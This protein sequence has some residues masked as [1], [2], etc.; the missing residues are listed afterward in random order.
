MRSCRPEPC[1]P[2]RGPSPWSSPSRGRGPPSSCPEP[3]CSCSAAVE[4]PERG[5]RRRP[6]RGRWCSPIGR[7]GAVLGAAAVDRSSPIGCCH[8]ARRPLCT[9][10]RLFPLDSYRG[11]V[12]DTRSASRWI[13]DNAAQCVDCSALTGAIEP[14]PYFSGG[15]VSGERSQRRI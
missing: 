12:E 10:V 15:L 2:P 5:R 6:G 3:W 13:N 14:F 9:H 1:W 7:P 8:F 4:D 11:A